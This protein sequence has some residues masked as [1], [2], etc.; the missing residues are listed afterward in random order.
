M[1]L[2]LQVVWHCDTSSHFLKILVTSCELYN[3]VWVYGCVKSYLL[4]FLTWHVTTRQDEAHER[5]STI[6]IL[7]GLLKKILR[8]RR[9]LKL[10]VSSAT[11][12]AEYVRDFFTE[13]RSSSSK[14]TD[15][16][17]STEQ[18]NATILSVQGRSY[19]VDIHYLLEPCP[20]YVQC[21]VETV[22]KV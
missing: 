9:D 1:S 12:D 6:D 16:N 7:M 14:K 18:P 15:E 13:N 20:N 19:S 3:E 10:I 11:V 5:T 8:K 21:C 2:V 17:G 22:M 4:L